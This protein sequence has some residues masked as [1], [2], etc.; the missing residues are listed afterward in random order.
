MK[1]IWQNSKI[2]K[3]TSVAHVEASQ[4]VPPLDGSLEKGEYM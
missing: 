1:F 4:V 3:R 2:K